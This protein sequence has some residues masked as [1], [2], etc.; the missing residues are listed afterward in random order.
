MSLKICILYGSNLQLTLINPVAKKRSP[1]IHLQLTISHL[2]DEEKANQG[3]Q[4]GPQI[5][6]STQNCFR[7]M[8]LIWNDILNPRVGNAYFAVSSLSFELYALS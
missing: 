4:R 1:T 8:T 2:F 3:K 6:H 7:A 5:V